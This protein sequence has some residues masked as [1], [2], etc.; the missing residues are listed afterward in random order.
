LVI[1]PNFYQ[2]RVSWTRSKWID[3]GHGWIDPAKEAEASRI[4][5]KNGL[6]TLDEEYAS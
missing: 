3:P 5:M 6:S 4:R 2:N 1:A